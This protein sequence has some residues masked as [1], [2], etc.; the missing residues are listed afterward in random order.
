MEGA[1]N[2]SSKGFAPGANPTPVR[3]SASRR[4]ARRTQGRYRGPPPKGTRA[5]SAS[6]LEAQLQRERT[7]HPAPVWSMESCLRTVRMWHRSPV[8]RESSRRSAPVCRK[9]LKC[10]FM[11]AI[12][13]HFLIKGQPIYMRASTCRVFL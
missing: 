8:W 11:A 4:Y 9:S 7:R 5:A 2:E 13:S 1:W 12:L 3:S 6:R 10:L